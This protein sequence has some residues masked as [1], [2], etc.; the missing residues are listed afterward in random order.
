MANAKFCVHCGGP[1]TP[2]ARFC[3]SCGT[4][5]DGAS[6]PTGAG[7]RTPIVGM[8]P[9]LVPSL[10]LMAVLGYFIGTRGAPPA[11]AAAPAFADG[12]PIVSAPD[13]STLSPEERVDRLFN[14]VM[15]LAGAGKSDSV[16]FFAPMAISALQAL[17]P[18][19]EHRRYDLGLIH[20]AS[21]DAAAARAQA[22]TILA[23]K[24][25]H[26]LGLALGM[27]AAN[28]LGRTADATRFG[29]KFTEVLTSERA[30]NLPEY[31]DHA[32]DVA[33]AIDEAAG[34][35]TSRIGQPR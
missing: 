17:M 3:A 13:I 34:R 16:A 2:A 19:D 21:G 27:R 1:L 15:T 20:L 10:A 8:L 25:T 5:L 31:A 7:G 14:R 9:W 24:P 30:K 18:L 28:A 23:A 6:S 29:A 33:E 22:D 4:S 26:L 35:R 11:P 12:A 32:P